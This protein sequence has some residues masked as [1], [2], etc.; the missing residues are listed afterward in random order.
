MLLGN[1]F[2]TA[3]Q[4][5]M[6]QPQPA[7]PANQ[8]PTNITP[9]PQ[10]NLITPDTTQETSGDPLL[11]YGT[12]WEDTPADPNNPVVEESAGYLPKI[13]P[14]QLSATINKLDFT[15]SIKPE[16][17]QAITQGGEA[18]ASALPEILN[19]VLRQSMLTSFNTSS[20]LMEAG[21][22]NSHKKF[23]QDISPRVKDVMLENSLQSSNKLMADPAFAPQVKAVRERYQAKFPKATPQQIE[24]A[25]NGYFDNMVKKMT[26]PGATSE[27][28]AT[29][30]NTKKLK[31]GDSAADWQSWFG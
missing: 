26:Q 19:T 2:N 25:V 17:L 4:N 15:K 13:D 18:A 7:Q 31:T 10:P 20:K 24:T 30:A 23:T 5:N 29:T 8:Q 16:L 1:P 14:A 12:L 27:E 6:Q 22:T 9:Q 28:D 21:F 3:Q 11:D